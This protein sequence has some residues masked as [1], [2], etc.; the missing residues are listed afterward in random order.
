MTVRSTGG[1]SDQQSLITARDDTIERAGG[2]TADAIG[3]QPFALAAGLE[4]AQSIATQC[5]VGHGRGYAATDW[6]RKCAAA[7]FR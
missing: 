1:R 5:Q 7:R 3:D 2:E 4:A 6:R